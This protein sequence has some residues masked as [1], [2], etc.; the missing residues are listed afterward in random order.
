ML[1]FLMMTTLS[2][3]SWELAL[4]SLTVMFLISIFQLKVSFLSGL[5]SVFFSSSSISALLV[6]LSVFV[7]MFSLVSSPSESST[8]F[9]LTTM[10]LVYILVLAFKASS[11]MMFYI[12]FEASLIP[13]LFL[14]VSWG[15]QP[16]RLQAGVYMV[17]YMIFA[18]FPLLF[19]ILWQLEINGTSNIMVLSSLS[20]STL[21]IS[22]SLVAFLAFL[23][24]TPI[25]GPHLWLPKA[26]VE[27]P[28][29]GSMI[30]AGVLLKLG[31]YGIFVMLCSFEIPNYVKTFTVCLSLTGGLM[32]T[33]LCLRQVDLKALIAYS[34]IGHMGLVTSGL[35]MGQSWSISSSFITMFAHGV[36]SPALFCL[37]YFLYNKVK[38]RSLLYLSGMISLIPTL[39]FFW[40]IFCSINMAIPPSLN[41]LGE[42]FILPSIFFLTPITIL[43]VVGLMIFFSAGYNMFLYSTV[44][45]GA[46]SK[47][48][49]PS[50][51]MKSF[52]LITL[53]SHLFPLLLIFK[54]EI[55]ALS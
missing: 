36:T 2:I 20:K 15:S 35:M 8:T 12:F 6:T 52:E 30:L 47:M 50:S 46:P 1:S 33:L 29:A 3:F 19:F 9:V 22:A 21:A 41:L 34:S 27:A 39:S 40:F 26:H 32:T 53:A 4:F 55:F 48:A 51:G 28:L 54:A 23:V 31:G 11:L 45:H 10:G 25:Y 38:T 24:K 5:D 14:I 44:N 16:E 49:L 37:A 43:L 13:T 7:I 18:S 17:C 42:I